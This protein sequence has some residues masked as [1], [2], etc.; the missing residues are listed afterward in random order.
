MHSIV[1]RCLQRENKPEDIYVYNHVNY[2]HPYLYT[3]THTY[4]THS[5]LTYNIHIHIL[6]HLVA[7]VHIYTN[8]LRPIYLHTYVYIHIR[9]KYMHAHTYINIHIYKYKHAYR[10]TYILTYI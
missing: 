9:S 6:I 10:H 8:E 7:L 1:G 2:Q 3:C 4:I 5:L